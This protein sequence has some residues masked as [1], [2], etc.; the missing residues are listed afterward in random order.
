MSLRERCAARSHSDF[1][2]QWAHANA[3]LAGGPD[4]IHPP[5]S[6]LQRAA[7]PLQ[8]N[9]TQGAHASIPI[10][11]TATATTNGR[12]FQFPMASHRQST[13]DNTNDQR[14]IAALRQASIPRTSG[15]CESDKLFRNCSL[16]SANGVL[17][18]PILFM[19]SPSQSY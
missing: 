8:P 14:A 19:T 7:S 17:I 16:T 5:Q 10:R 13:V 1:A 2:L 3:S 18:E 11:H 15:L 9:R 12:H 4:G 6:F